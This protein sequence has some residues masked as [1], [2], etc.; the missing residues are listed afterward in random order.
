[1]S[2]SV[3]MHPSFQMGGQVLGYPLDR[4]I[5]FKKKKKST[6]SIPQAFLHFSREPNTKTKSTTN[7]SNHPSTTKDI[8]NM[9]RKKHDSLK[10]SNSK[11]DWKFSE[12]LEISTKA[13]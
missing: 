7:P 11:L 6:P 9:K 10:I 12:R 4:K 2:V 5:L 8:R 13:H 3:S 1:M